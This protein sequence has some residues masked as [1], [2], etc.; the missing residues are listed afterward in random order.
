MHRYLANSERHIMLSGNPFDKAR[1]A[2]VPIVHS[3]C[4]QIPVANICRDSVS[5]FSAKGSSGEIP[6]V[7]IPTPRNQLSLFMQVPSG[8]TCLMQCFGK[9]VGAAEEG[10]HIKPAYY[11]IAYVVTQQSC[12]YDAPIKTC[13]TSDDV[14]V[15]VDVVLVFRITDAEK[16]VYRLGAPNFNEFLQ[17][18]TDEA[19]RVLVRKQTHETVYELRGTKADDMLQMLNEKFLESGV[20]FEDVKIVSVWL[21]PSLTKYLEFTTSTQ[22]TMMKLER[23]QEFEVLQVRQESEMQIEEIER[24]CEQVLI[25]ESGRKKRAQL[26]FEQQSIKAE[27]EGRVNM[28]QAEGKIQVMSL[29]TTSELQRKKTQLET[30][31]IREINKAE[32]EAT[33]LVSQADLAAEQRVIEAGYKE[34]Q[35]LCE[36]EIT[37]HEAQV[38]SQ[39]L[40]C[41]AQKRAHELVM[42]ER[43][44]L[45][46]FAAA[47]QFNLV[48][49]AGDHLIQAMMIGSVSGLEKA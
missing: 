18:T 45:A 47:G 33:T 6:L 37:K 24:Q 48:G 7:L 25:S 43:E 34:Q 8:V 23:Q 40:T 15:D 39:S 9:N 46:S 41:L 31:R 30:E 44:I 14:R 2:R 3:R 35:M 36:A 13:P 32:M 29:V 12:T 26:T 22:N 1:E 49:A 20:A 5:L 10:L 27:E 42:R 38:Q 16:F 19:I 21:P 11:R 4:V 17:G 28:I